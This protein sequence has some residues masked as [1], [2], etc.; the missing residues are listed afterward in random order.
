MLTIDTIPLCSERR[1]SCRHCHKADKSVRTPLLVF[2]M[3][4]VLAAATAELVEL[5]PV[6]RVLLI[7]CRHVIALFALRALQNNII[8]RHIS[9]L[10]A[11]RVYA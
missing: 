6:R 3:Q 9:S 5:Q 4:L 1:H 8:S 2:S 10:Y 11:L 7:L